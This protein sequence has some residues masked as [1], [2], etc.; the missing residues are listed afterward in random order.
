MALY[1][2]EV[3]TSVTPLSQVLQ[4]SLQ[5]FLNIELATLCWLAGALEVG[6]SI[7]ALS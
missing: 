6:I 5:V 3:L 4:S 2:T 7:I 1:S